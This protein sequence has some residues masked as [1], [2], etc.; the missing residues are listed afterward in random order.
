M[1]YQNARNL[2]DGL[3]DRA[4]L[5]DAPAFGGAV[6]DEAASSLSA[7]EMAEYC[8]AAIAASNQSLASTAGL[9]SASADRF[10]A[11]FPHYSAQTEASR[12]S[13]RATSRE[14]ELALAKW[15]V[16]RDDGH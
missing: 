5:M 6:E 4:G 2:V 1:G 7:L 10:D 16:G 3:F 13:T 8:D 12:R 11:W 14:L 9:L 15:N